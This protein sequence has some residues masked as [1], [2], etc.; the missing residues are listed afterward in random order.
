MS[1]TLPKHTSLPTGPGMG[2]GT[3][4]QAT[5]TKKGV[6]QKFR[7]GRPTGTG[8]STQTQSS[9]T[10][11]ATAPPGLSLTRAG[12]IGGFGLVT[13]KTGTGT[14]I[15]NKVTSAVRGHKTTSTPTGGMGMGG[16]V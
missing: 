11:L 7:G 1:V 14:G 2:T 4:T 12:P 16:G 10:G 15:W 9:G 3:S 13:T 8:T 5:T 6:W